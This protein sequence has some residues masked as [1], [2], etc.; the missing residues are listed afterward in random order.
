MIETTTHPIE[1]L[2]DIDCRHPANYDF[3]NSG[4]DGFY[5]PGEDLLGCFHE[6]IFNGSDEL[7]EKWQEANHDLVGDLLTPAERL[8][9][10]R[11]RF[12]LIRS[13]A[14]H[15]EAAA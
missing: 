8:M 14:Q 6:N 12:A 9:F 1:I 11:A 2:W 13:A 4:D 10:S 15:L 5:G 3:S 7:M